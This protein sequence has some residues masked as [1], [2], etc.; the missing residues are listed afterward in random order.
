MSLSEAGIANAL[1]GR[2]LDLSPVPLIAWE[3]RRPR[4]ADGTVWDT[5]PDDQKP[6]LA[7]ETIPTLR[8]DPTLKGGG[9]RA[10]SE[11][12]MQVMVI[13]TR[14]TWAYTGRAL[15]DDVMA[16]Y[17]AGKRLSVV[18]GGTVEITGRVNMVP[19][20]GSETDWRQGVR[21][22]YTARN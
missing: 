4:A 21:I 2:L 18:G 12:Y 5:V 20:Y 13:C 10:R 14:D 3:N 7:V 15:L 17:Y 16:L 8:S 22:H 11:G 1:G 6:Y 19:G 9:T